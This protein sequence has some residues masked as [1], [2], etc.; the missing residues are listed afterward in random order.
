MFQ[1]MAFLVVSLKIY[2]N[3]K[4]DQFVELKKENFF[5]NTQTF[6]VDQITVRNVSLFP[7]TLNFIEN[8][9]CHMLD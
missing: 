8:V 3:I 7:K 6:G 1:N 5:R 9:A 2:Q 4:F